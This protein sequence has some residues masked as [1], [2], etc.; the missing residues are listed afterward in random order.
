[1]EKT[2]RRSVTRGLLR[3]PMFAAIAKVTLFGPGVGVAGDGDNDRYAHENKFLA[4]RVFRWLNTAERRYFEEGSRYGNLEE[5]RR[6]AAV[7]DWLDSSKAGKAQIGRSCIQ[8]SIS[9]AA[10]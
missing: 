6:S 1:M 5:L 8:L 7:E 2:T 3:V 4:V 9:T 10:K